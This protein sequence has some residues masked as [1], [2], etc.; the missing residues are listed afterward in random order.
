MSA[1]LHALFAANTASILI[2]AAQHGVFGRAKW[3]VPEECESLVKENLFCTKRFYYYR[4]DHGPH[5]WS[6][7]DSNGDTLVVHTTLVFSPRFLR[8]VDLT[9]KVVPVREQNGIFAPWRV[10]SIK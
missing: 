2:Y 8:P 7:M 3:E 6:N 1:K 9:G 5:H 10:S 4:N